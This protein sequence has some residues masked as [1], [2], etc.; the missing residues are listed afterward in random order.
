MRKESRK[1][2]SVEVVREFNVETFEMRI[3]NL[4]V[5]DYQPYGEVIV[6][7][8]SIGSGTYI[9]MMVQYK[10]CDNTQMLPNGAVLT[11]NGGYTGGC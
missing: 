3:N 4:I 9:L 5:D 1:I 6:N 7:F 8:N 10:T 11:R 2:I